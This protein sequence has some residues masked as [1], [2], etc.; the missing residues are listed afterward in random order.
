VMDQLNNIKREDFER[1]LRQAQFENKFKPIKNIDNLNQT[2][3]PQKKEQLYFDK[4]IVRSTIKRDQLNLKKRKSLEESLGNS[5]VASAI[6]FLN[7][8]KNW[9]LNFGGAGDLILLIANAYKDAN[10]QIVFLANAGS[11]EFCKEILEF[12]KLECFVSKNIMGTKHASVLNDY[13]VQKINFKP[14]AHLSRGLYF[15]DWARDIEYYKNRMVLKTDWVELFGKNPIFK[16]E[17]VIILQPSGSFRSYD[18]QRYLEVF[19]YN[20]IVKKF[21]DLEYSVITT[22]SESDKDYYKWKPTNKKDWFMSSQKLFGLKHLMPINLN[23]FMQTINCAE[24]V[25]SADTWL[26][27]YSLLCSIPTFV[28]GNRHRG[29]YL[30]VGADPC[31]HIFLNKNIWE[32]LEIKTVEE[33]MEMN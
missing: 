17:K 15:G 6:D 23:L 29:N 7:P 21:I 19:E 14:S 3:L 18:R 20:Y 4:Q 28:F 24:K 31:D 32:N 10:A 1:L 12:F 16:N 9:Y 22:G 11:M 8:S 33:I 5:T 27:S 30:P 25:I 2:I 13:M 26:K